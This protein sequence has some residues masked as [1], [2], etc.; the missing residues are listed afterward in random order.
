MEIQ[1]VAGLSGGQP[2]PH[3]VDE[4]G[5]F[6]EG[7]HAQSTVTKGAAQSDGDGGFAR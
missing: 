3:W 7:L 4:V 1:V 6:F 2:Q 5:A